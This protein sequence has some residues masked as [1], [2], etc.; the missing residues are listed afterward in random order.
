MP[1]KK[2]VMRYH[3]AKFRLAQW[4]MSHFPDHHTYV[5]PFGGAA[6]VL[7]QKP[8]SMS[9]V[10]NDLDA[11][12]YNVFKVL[13][14]KNQT[15][16]LQRLLLVTPYSRNEFELS[17]EETTD[18]VEQARRTIIRAHMGFGSAGATKHQTGFRI[19]SA[20]KYG[21]AAH[22]WFEYPAEIASFGNR[23]QG[24][25]L[26]N[27]PAIDVLKNH[28]R[29]DTL[30]FVDPPYLHET[31]SMGGHS[32]CYNHEMTNEDHEELLDTLQHLEGYVVLSGYDSGQYNDLL[33]GWEKRSTTARISAGRGT[34]IR[35][36]CI[37]LNNACAK[38]QS[39]HRL[40]L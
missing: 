35:T 4:V 30:F 18:P 37:W 21:T 15:A 3:G 22:L 38:H 20:R 17:Y 28:D 14:D 5:E 7:L 31:R 27:R 34:G 8:R 29:E 9:E 32:R 39:Q 2:P 36:E 33:P 11:D 16:E 13:Q 26:E 23:L 40:A 25:V 1:I 24:V 10:Y 19:D 12:I 6:G